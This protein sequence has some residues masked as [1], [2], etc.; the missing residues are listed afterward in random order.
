MVSHEWIRAQLTSTKREPNNEAFAARYVRLVLSDAAARG[1]PELRFISDADRILVEYREGPRWHERDHLPIRLWDVLL[2]A[3]VPL[4]GTT[5]M[6]TNFS[7]GAVF[8]RFASAAAKGD[9]DRPVQK[10]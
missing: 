10:P 8:L 6:E 4:L 2:A 7:E 9:G 3:I 5:G 1:W